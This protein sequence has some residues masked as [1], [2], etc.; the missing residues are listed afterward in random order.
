VDVPVPAGAPTI[1][2]FFVDANPFIAS[3][4]WPF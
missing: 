1:R 3:C 2:A 4:A